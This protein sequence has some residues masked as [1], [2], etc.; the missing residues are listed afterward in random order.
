M[1]LN[2]TGS[3][4]CKG[5]RLTPL[6]H[7]SNTMILHTTEVMPLPNYRLFCASTQANLARSIWPASLKVRCLAL[8]ATRRC[9]PPLANTPC[10]A[11]WLGRMALTWRRSSCLN[12]WRGSASSRRREKTHINSSQP[13][14]NF[15]TMVCSVDVLSCRKAGG[16]HRVC[17]YGEVCHRN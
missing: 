15:A 5:N 9:L 12:C 2:L 8:C 14:V 6:I 3:W 1:K 10:C 17:L 7:L 11:P 13:R 16:S 4:P